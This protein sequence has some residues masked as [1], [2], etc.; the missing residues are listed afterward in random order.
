MAT[1]ETKNAEKHYFSP[2]LNLHGSLKMV[3]NSSI[4]SP[5]PSLHF[6]FVSLG[7]IHGILL[8]TAEASV[9]MGWDRGIKDL[10]DGML[11]PHRGSLGLLQSPV[12]EDRKEHTPL[13]T[14]RSVPKEHTRRK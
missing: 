4:T 14:S 12:S 9:R 5:L 13:Y 6:Y 7:L 2:K 11:L 10:E 1:Q 8:I 3:Q